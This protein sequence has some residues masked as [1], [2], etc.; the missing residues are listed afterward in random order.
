VLA[1]IGYPQLG[2]MKIYLIVPIYFK[3][4]L[5]IV[6]SVNHPV[7]QRIYCSFH[8]C[9]FYFFAILIVCFLLFYEKNLPIFVT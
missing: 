1:I 5:S 6:I 9:R 4:L 3:I 7:Q 2:S 8:F